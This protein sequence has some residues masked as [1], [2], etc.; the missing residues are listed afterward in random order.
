[1]ASSS[2]IKNCKI[3]HCKNEHCHKLTYCR[4]IGLISISELK[5]KDREL[6]QWRCE[7]SLD[8]QDQ[9][10]FHHEKLYLS[11]YENLQKYCCDPFSLHKKHI[12]SKL[13]IL[14]SS[15]Q[16]HISTSFIITANKMC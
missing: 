16:S 8:D 13:N 15:T 6:L 10:C 9:V 5:Q 4:K 1:M 14:F 3:G 7:I 12:T 11:R 2:A